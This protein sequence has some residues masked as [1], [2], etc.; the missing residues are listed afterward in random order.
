MAY[1]E[2]ILLHSGAQR[3]SIDKH[4]GCMTSSAYVV[5]GAL[6]DEPPPFSDNFTGKAVQGP[7]TAHVVYPAGL[8]FYLA[9]DDPVQLWNDHN[10]ICRVGREHS[11]EFI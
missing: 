4:S 11:K 7:E 10:G 8:H 3:L 2:S 5:V 6:S 9:T 1:K